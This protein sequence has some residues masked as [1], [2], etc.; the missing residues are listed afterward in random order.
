MRRKIQK[1]LELL[2]KDRPV[3][4]KRNSRFLEDVQESKARIFY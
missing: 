3:M 2:I 1:E 4:E